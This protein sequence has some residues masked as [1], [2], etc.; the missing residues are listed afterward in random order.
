MQLE[1]RKYLHDVRE[2]CSRVREFTEGKSFD[3]YQASPML[4]AAVERQ[5]EIIGV[6]PTR[7]R[8]SPSGSPTVA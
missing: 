7:H 8:T 5:F 6:F 1:V 2:A 3:D 4:R